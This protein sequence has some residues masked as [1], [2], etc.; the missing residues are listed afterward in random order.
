MNVEDRKAVAQIVAHSIR[1]AMTQGADVPFLDK[2]EGVTVL[3][4]DDSLAAVIID[5]VVYLIGVKDVT[6]EVEE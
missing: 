1:Y 2:V 6:W 4:E 3:R 5:G